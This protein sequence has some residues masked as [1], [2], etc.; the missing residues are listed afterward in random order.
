M[1]RHVARLRA[2]GVAIIYISHRLD[3]VRRI[4]DRI[5]VLRD[6]RVVASEPA[7]QLDMARAVRLMVGT[8]SGEDLA[9]HQRQIGSAG[10]SS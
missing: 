4:A 10:A 7:H 8:G 1:F 6:G 3:E 2:G 9:G 5:S